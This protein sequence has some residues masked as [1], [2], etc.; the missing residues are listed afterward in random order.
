MYTIHTLSWRLL[1]VI[2]SLFQ[3]R[4]TTA[5]QFYVTLV[6]YDDIIEVD[7]SDEVIGILSETAWSAVLPLMMLTY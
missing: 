7:V 5:D 4:K 2:I 1:Y 6:T 3:V